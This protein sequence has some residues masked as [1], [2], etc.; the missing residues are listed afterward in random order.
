MTYKEH[1]IFVATRR[2]SGGCFWL[3]LANVCWSEGETKHV[4]SVKGRPQDRF[5][6]ASEAETSA[7]EIAREWVDIHAQDGS[8]G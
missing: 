1:R 8:L 4:V 7:I 2:D 3:P 5:L 6:Y